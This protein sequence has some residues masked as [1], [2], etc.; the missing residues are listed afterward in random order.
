ME[1][2]IVKSD[3]TSSVLLIKKV[4]DTNEIRSITHSQTS[5][6]QCLSVLILQKG[7]KK[8]DFAEESS[9]HNTFNLIL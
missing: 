9:F 3:I 6:F 4:N 2:Y 1:Y 8:G 7:R 5:W